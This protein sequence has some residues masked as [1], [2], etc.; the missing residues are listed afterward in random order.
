M[1]KIVENIIAEVVKNE[2]AD[3]NYYKKEELVNLKP[4]DTYKGYKI[5]IFDGEWGEVYCFYK[6]ENN[7]LGV[8]RF[9]EKT[10]GGKHSVQTK[11]FQSFEKGMGTIMTSYLVDK[12]HG[13]FYGP[14]N[15]VSA[16]GMI[17][18]FA[19]NPEYVLFLYSKTKNAFYKTKIVNDEIVCEDPK[20]KVYGSMASWFY[21]T[22]KSFITEAKVLVGV[23]KEQA[24]NNR[25]A[26]CKNEEIYKKAVK[27]VFVNKDTATWKEIISQ[28]KYNLKS[29][30]HVTAYYKIKNKKMNNESAQIKNTLQLLEKVVNLQEG[31]IRIL[32]NGKFHG[33]VNNN[34][35]LEQYLKN[36]NLKK[37]EYKLEVSA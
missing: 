16:T 13:F 19:S 14:L 6:E 37:G 24:L 28:Y 17:K 35:E 26:E 5:G 9:D 11:F 30:F 22:K 7:I 2:V 36:N 23:S 32:V 34:L 18:K 12:Y 3:Q 33:K 27:S 31:E 20:M 1:K 10:Y 15:S 25:P 29:Y 8:V 21:L 4:F